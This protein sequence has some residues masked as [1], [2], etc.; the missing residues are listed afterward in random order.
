MVTVAPGTTALL[1]SVTVPRTAA[2]VRWANAD[3]GSIDTRIAS[4]KTHFLVRISTA[5]SDGY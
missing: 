4:I 2:L 5:P 3:A 1:G